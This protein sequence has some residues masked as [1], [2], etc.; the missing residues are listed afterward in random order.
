VHII[1]NVQQTTNALLDGSVAGIMGLAFQGLASTKAVP[2][3][4][5]LLNNNQLSSPEMSF[6]LT[7]FVNDND[8]KAEEPGGVLTLGGRNTSLFT[9]DVQFLNMPSGVTPSF[10]LLEMSSAYN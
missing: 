9:G 5:A 4:Q 1:V 2:F 10:W 8:A 7:R 3:W 6:W